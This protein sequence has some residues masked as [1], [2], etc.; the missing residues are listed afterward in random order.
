MAPQFNPPNFLTQTPG[1]M[2]ALINPISQAVSTIPSLWDQYKLRR[3]EEQ[4]LLADQ[5][6]KQKEIQSKFGT[7]V[8]KVMAPEV[9][10]SIPEM[11]RNPDIVPG[12]ETPEQQLERLGSE[13]YKALNPT[14]T[15][16]ISATGAPVGVPVPGKAV[17]LPGE[18]PSPGD[19][20]SEKLKIKIASEKP[21]ALG[22]YNNTMREFD[23]MITEAKAI[24]DDPAVSSATGLTSF[25][26]K[27]PG[28]NAKRVASRLETLKAKTLLNVLSSLKELSRTGASGFGQLSEI[29]G[30]N[31]RNSI[32]TLDRGQKKADFQASLD[33]FIREMELKKEDVRNTFNSVYGGVPQ[34]TPSNPTPSVPK[35]GEQFNGAK[36]LNIKRLD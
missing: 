8:T 2:E 11:I 33:R 24:R 18:K 29:E 36:V 4:A 22:S 30:E 23:N 12:K 6:M 10:N 34:I 14:P 19:K 32:S 21:K 9:L 1:K 20:E 5:Q 13:G 25:W 26:G 15:Q 16:I 7:G 3:L 17:V 31:I 28:T 27:M 35:V